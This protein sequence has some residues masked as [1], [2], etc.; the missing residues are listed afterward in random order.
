MV[1]GT[2]SMQSSV[3]SSRPDAGV[4]FVQQDGRGAIIASELYE[5]RV[6]KL[7]SLKRSEVPKY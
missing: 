3:E 4:F 1:A 2:S 7:I 5:D 6:Q